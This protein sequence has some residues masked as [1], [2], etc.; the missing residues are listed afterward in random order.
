LERIVKKDLSIVAI[1][2]RKFRKELERRVGVKRKYDR[3]DNES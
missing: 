1:K 2:V 3:Y